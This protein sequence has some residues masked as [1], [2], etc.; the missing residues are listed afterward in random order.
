MAKSGTA[1]PGLFPQPEIQRPWHFLCAT[2]RDYLKQTTLPEGICLVANN[3]HPG[4]CID[5]GIN[6]DYFIDA[7][8]V[9][10][11]VMRE[12]KSYCM[13]HLDDILSRG[14][15]DL[16]KN[17]LEQVD[18]CGLHQKEPFVSYNI[19]YDLL[20]LFCEEGFA[21]L[22]VNL[23]KIKTEETGDLVSLSKILWFRTGNNEAVLKLITPVFEE[24]AELMRQDT[25]MELLKITGWL[26]G[27]EKTA[28]KLFRLHAEMIGHETNPVFY[29][30]VRRYI[31]GHSPA[32]DD[33]IHQAFADRG[34][35]S[36]L[37]LNVQSLAHHFDLQLAKQ[38]L[39]KGKGQAAQLT[40]MLNFAYI[41]RLYFGDEEVS[42]SFME[43]AKN[44]AANFADAVLLF[45]NSY[46]LGYKVKE[47]MGLVR[48]FTP[49]DM[50]DV[51]HIAPLLIHYRYF[52]Q[53]TRSYE[54]TMKDLLFGDY[55][56]ADLLSVATE[57]KEFNEYA[58]DLDR[59]YIQAADQAVDSEDYTQLA[60]W[61][62]YFRQDEADKV[63]GYLE[64]AEELAGL[65]D[66]YMLL[67]DLY[68]ETDDKEQSIRLLEK[69]AEH[70][71]TT[72]EALEAASRW[73]VWSK[74]K[75]LRESLLL[76]ESLAQS[77]ADFRAIA[78]E[79]L[80]LCNDE[81]QSE[82]CVN[83]AVELGWVE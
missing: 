58:S 27:E 2:F 71:V 64:K 62:I 28:Q 75:K 26:L 49:E 23:D 54:S 6:R 33:L 41:Y 60:R 21:S 72:E 45:L 38:L 10:N 67:S 36:H 48:Q 50:R 66:E 35:P 83:K 78:M 47:A 51:S 7:S 76:A 11:L 56:A 25:L 39:D 40:D 16:L 22:L 81:E 61:I 31:L 34:S 13:V 52:L 20:C 1:E 80:H 79:W 32:H 5:K 18:R 77:A 68:L 30:A 70:I 8:L 82:R 12:G 44:S 74:K 63:P 17:I 19:L 69:A 3:G 42:A 15:E 37:L 73:F 24:P 59:L 65:Y 46:R 14:D 29:A 9:R 55:V 57:L 53:D 4:L 43:Q